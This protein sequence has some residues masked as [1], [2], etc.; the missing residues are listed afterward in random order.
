MEVSSQVESQVS[1]PTIIAAHEPIPFCL[2]E[3]IMEIIIT[4]P[5]NHAYRV[6]NMVQISFFMRSLIYIHL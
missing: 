3:K 6:K 4:M 1:C 2:H 5:R